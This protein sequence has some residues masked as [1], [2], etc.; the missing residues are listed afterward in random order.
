MGGIGKITLAQHAFNNEEVAKCFDQKVWICVSDDFNRSK[1]L[2][3]MVSSRTVSKSEKF[4]HYRNSDLL[5]ELEKL[6]IPLQASQMRSAK[7]VVTT[8]ESK[9]LRK[10]DE[11][12]KIV[13]KGLEDDDYWEFF[14][15]CAFGGTEA[16][17]HPSLQIIGYA[18]REF[19]KLGVNPGKLAII[20]KEEEDI[21]STPDA[22]EETLK[23]LL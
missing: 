20:S 21:I 16:N 8:R 6:L 23:S 11:K 10:Q 2:Q 3:G 9:V 1:I 14:G 7:I 22:M 15:S 17:E 18:V 19:A 12:N 13:L 4:S 5:E